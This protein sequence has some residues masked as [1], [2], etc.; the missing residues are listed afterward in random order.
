MEVFFKE[1]VY[2]CTE[3]SKDLGVHEVLNMSF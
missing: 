1:I 3:I 2:V